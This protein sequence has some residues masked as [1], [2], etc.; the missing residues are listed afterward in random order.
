VSSRTARAIQRNPVSKNKTKPKQ[1]NKQTKMSPEHKMT[2]KR[3]SP[4]NLKSHPIRFVSY[5]G[6][7][8]IIPDYH[9]HLC[10]TILKTF[11]FAYIAP[12]MVLSGHPDIFPC[13]ALIVIASVLGFWV[14]VV[15]VVVVVVCQL[16]M[17]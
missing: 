13:I 10:S 9:L 6:F 3:L 15:V 4:W 1:T 8:L 11:P 16:D 5:M 2:T 7:V 14:F 17:N 12:R